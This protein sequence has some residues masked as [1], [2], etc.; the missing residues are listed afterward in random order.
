MLY[1]S[2]LPQGAQVTASTRHPSVLRPRRGAEAGPGGYL[3]VC[4]HVFMKRNCKAKTSLKEIENFPTGPVG[5]RCSRI[6]HI[7]DNLT[8]QAVSLSICCKASC[9]LPGG[10]STAQ[11]PSHVGKRTYQEDGESWVNSSPR[12]GEPLCSSTTPLQHQ[13][14]V[15]VL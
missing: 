9:P 4:L 8:P 10:S 1:L 15:L 3:C 13:A 14:L 2:L 6:E 5:V 7:R 12:K 11:P